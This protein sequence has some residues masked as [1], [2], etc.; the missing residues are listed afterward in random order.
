MSITANTPLEVC[1]DR[2]SPKDPY[3]FG[4]AIQYS[5]PR[6]STM[7][8]EHHILFNKGR[9]FETTICNA[10][11]LHDLYELTGFE[12]QHTCMICQSW[13]DMEDFVIAMNILGYY[14]EIDID[15]I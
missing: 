8:G 1:N 13:R 14:V 10:Q 9:Y 3:N 7:N 6:R 11:L 4:K 12:P 2:T 5:Q 15:W